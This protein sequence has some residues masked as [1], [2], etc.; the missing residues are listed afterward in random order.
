MQFSQDKVGSQVRTRKRDVQDWSPGPDDRTA[1]A[2]R[3]Q[4]EHEESRGRRFRKV[5]GPSHRIGG[6]LGAPY[7]LRVPFIQRG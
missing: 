5:Q 2:C 3:R 4:Q 1:E 7:L 6:A